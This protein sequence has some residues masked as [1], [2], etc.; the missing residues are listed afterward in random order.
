MNA[1]TDLWTIF[2]RDQGQIVEYAYR[3]ADGSDSIICR[4]HDRSD[5]TTEYSA[6]ACPDDVDWTG[7]EG[8]APW[9]HLDWT[10]C[11]NP[12]SD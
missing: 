9:G 2:G 1:M 4:C 12:F 11:E 8:E 10:C 7:A 5:D 6:A 3:Y